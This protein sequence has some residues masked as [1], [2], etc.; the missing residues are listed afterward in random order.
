MNNKL[1]NAVL[2]VAACGV[3]TVGCADRVKKP[4][5]GRLDPWAPPQV[6][7]ASTE[8]RKQTAVG[9]PQL[10][11]DDAG[12]LLYVTLPIRATTNKNLY[13]DY[14]VTFLDAAGRAVGPSSWQTTTLQGNV[15]QRVTANS[16]SQQAVDFQLDLRWAR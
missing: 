3:L 10:S 5:E 7:F 12:N 2:S 9:E 15:A 14:R 4:I 1:I 6:Q 11:R 16:T 13:V 8:L